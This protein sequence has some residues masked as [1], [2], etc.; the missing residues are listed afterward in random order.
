MQAPFRAFALVAVLILSPLG[1]AGCGTQTTNL[2]T[3]E[4]ERGAYSWQEEVQLGRDADPQIRAAFGVYDDDALQAYVEQLGQEVLQV[5]AYSEPTTPAEVRNTPFSFAVLDSP[6]PNAMALP[7]GYIY[8]TRGLL[9]HLDN[10]AQLAVVLGHEIGHVLARHA[11]RQAYSAQ[12]GQLGLIGAA[13]LSDVI[14]AGDRV[15]QGILQYGGTGVQLLFLKYSRDAEREA[16]L[17]GVAYAEYAG[18][19]ASTAAAFFTALERISAQ[20]GGGI[21][22]FL[23]TH[24]DPAER[25]VTIPEL[26]AQYDT[27]TQVNQAQYLNRVESLVLGDNPRQGFVESSTFYHPD[28]RFRFDVPRG[29][30][31]SNGAAAVQ[32][33][34]P[35]GQAILE[36]TFAREQASPEAAARAFAAQE[37]FNL[38]DQEAT[39]VNGLSAYAVSGTANTQQG[40]LAIAAYFIEYDGNVYSLTGL[41]AASNFTRY[42][43]NFA[44]TFLSFDRLTNASILNRQ[45][46]RMEVIEASRTAPFR[47]F[48]QGRP[49]PIGMNEEGLAIMN[50]VQ[51][52][53]TISAGTMLKLPED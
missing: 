51:L 27:G 46:I 41:T 8:V 33:A 13:V 29:W 6:V 44:S 28:L 53:E 37:G 14:G 10:E 31:T 22:P 16:D 45:P 12:T 5:S 9:A 38:A 4:T 32:M 15:T 42:R 30:N 21:Q 34:E 23:S 26:A 19:E 17:A 35:N 18:Y 20:G 40:E 25:A 1:L 47:Q 2:V 24:P 3:G 49:M 43:D 48:L 36:F 50:N 39:R 11:S 52:G 7:G